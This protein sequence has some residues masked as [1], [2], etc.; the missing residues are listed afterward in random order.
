MLN[1]GIGSTFEIGGLIAV[2]VVLL[3][4]TPADALNSIDLSPSEQH[5]QDGSDFTF[6]L[7]I[8]FDDV[9]I[10]GGVGI[11]FDP[12]LTLVSFTF[13]PAFSEN[14]GLSSPASGE[15][16]VIQEIAFGWVF[17]P[18][19]GETGL[20]TVGQLTFRADVPGS[21]VVIMTSSSLT[22]P[23]QFF[24]PAGP[25]VPMS[26]HLGNTGAMVVEVNIVP[27]PQTAVLLGLGIL[28]LAWGARVLDPRANRT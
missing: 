1:R 27:E 23:D 25:L 26:I 4:S 22:T 12:L 14:F 15:T 7:M 11:T 10:G 6:D 20:H 16:V 3:G 21:T 17:G 2:A 19:F 13:D 8:D 18:E 28:G 24:G 9:A 5:V